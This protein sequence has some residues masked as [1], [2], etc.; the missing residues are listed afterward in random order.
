MTVATTNMVP[1]KIK[2]DKI[3]HVSII[4]STY[5][6]VF[7]ICMASRS[8]FIGSNPEES[9]LGGIRAL[10]FSYYAHKIK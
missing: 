1:K 10:F 5:I 4:V 6:P 9:P 2:P 8:S 3:T 7:S